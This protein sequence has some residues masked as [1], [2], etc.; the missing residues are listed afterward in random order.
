MINKQ[1]QLARAIQIAT[2]VHHGQFDKGG[3]PYI[4]HPL[5]LMQ[6]LLFDVQLATIAVL[7]DVI[8]DSDGKVTIE[9]LHQ[10][11]FSNRVCAAV[12]LLTHR[13]G[14]DYL[15][16]YVKRI[17]TSYDAIRVKRK[18]L[19]HNSNITRLKGVTEKD[20]NR[21]KKYHHAFLMLTEAKRV[22]ERK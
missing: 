11:G 17:S 2:N 1:A 19:E 20:L 5:H 9:G 15:D 3:N 4:L 12:E 8:E 21:M 6:Q 7:H 13:E 18:D 10:E 16:D 22:F 14:D